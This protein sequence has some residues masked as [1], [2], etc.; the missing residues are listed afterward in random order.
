MYKGCVLDY[1]LKL[2][3]KVSF[4]FAPMHKAIASGWTLLFVL[5]IIWGTSF[6]LIKKGL[7]AYSPDELAC[8]RISISALALLPF[9]WTKRLKLKRKTLLPIAMFG[10]CNGGFP[11]FL[12]AFAE[13]HVSSS[14]AGMLNSLSPFFT[15]LIG[16]FFFRT[17][18]NRWNLSGVVLGMLGAWLIVVT[19][20]QEIGV[21]DSQASLASVYLIIATV[22]YGLSTNI[23]KHYLQDVPALV[24][25]TFSF[26]FTALPA[27][28]YLFFF[29]DF[30]E[31]TKSSTAGISLISITILAV[32]GSAF[33]IILYSKLIQIRG[34]LFGSFVT[35]LM[36][37][38][39]LAWGILDGE[40]F[41]F[42]QLLGLFVV[43]SAI[44]IAGGK[45]KQ[46]IP[47]GN[48]TL[49]Q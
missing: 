34:A 22:C 29:S 13:E 43:L 8:L 30:V 11:P 10:L 19:R 24:I 37:F 20:N 14:M 7:L 25:S 32:V 41:S 48:R 36:P 46:I 6:I 9:A 33:A 16:A 49:R 42:L 1:L 18:L 47:S 3:T 5:S 40:S 12:F 4:I 2:T 23:V 45:I 44:F 27:L 35:Y 31:H 39:A 26:Q 17:T 38:V 28:L 15:L 21:S